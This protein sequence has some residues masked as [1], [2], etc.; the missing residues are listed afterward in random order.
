MA[1][2][3]NHIFGRLSGVHGM[4]DS[5]L[6][7]LVSWGD[8]LKVDQAQIDAQHEGIFNIALEVAD[9]WHRHGDLEH[10][11]AL[12]GKLSTVLEGHFRYEER[13]L[14]AIAYPKLEAHKAEHQ[15]MLD[16]LK[17]IRDRLDGMGHGT[18]QMAPGFIVYNYILGITVGHI[19]QSDMAYC[20]YARDSQADQMPGW[21]VS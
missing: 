13:Q 20:A 2:A 17:I 21:P 6:K 9:A 8:H 7:Q 5:S 10:L 3:P 12:A 18:P 19:G 11:K 16:E 4:T 15:V 14:E 1:S